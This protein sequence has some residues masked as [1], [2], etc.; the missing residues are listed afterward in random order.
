M[1]PVVAQPEED[2]SPEFDGFGPGSAAE[3]G[4]EELKGF[5]ISYTRKRHFAR[6]HRVGG[7]H[8]T[9]GIDVHDFQYLDE[10]HEAAWDEF[11]KQCWR[12]GAVPPEEEGNQSST[13]SSSTEAVGEQEVGQ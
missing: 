13:S 4:E 3:M 6:L 8:R 2:T 1:K 11:C 10:P 12:H 5:Y 7:C 9:P